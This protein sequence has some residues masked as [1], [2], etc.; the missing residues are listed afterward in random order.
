VALFFL[1]ASAVVKRYAQEVGTAWVQ[2]LTAPLAGHSLVV[3]RITLAETVAALTRKERGGFL[4]PQ[5]AAT[6]LADFHY[7]FGRQYLVVE[8]SVPL[9]NYAASLARTHALRGYDAV[10]LAAALEVHG[11]DPSLTFISGDGGLNAAATAEGL[12]VDD[13]NSHP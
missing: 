9:V 5:N 4:T 8:V 10:Q 11:Q 13:P 3:V 6:A 12:L 1:D 7:D 2:A